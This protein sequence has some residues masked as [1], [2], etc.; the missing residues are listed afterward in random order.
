MQER[1][2]DEHNPLHVVVLR[3]RSKNLLLACSKLDSSATH[4]SLILSIYIAMGVSF[5]QM[6]A[7]GSAAFSAA[8]VMPSRDANSTPTAAA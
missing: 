8:D 2:L 1:T 7:N 6:S 3:P 5:H 4:C